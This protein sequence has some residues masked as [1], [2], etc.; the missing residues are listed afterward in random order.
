MLDKIE[1][2]DAEI[3]VIANVNALVETK[4]AD[5]RTH[6][7]EQAAHAVRWEESVRNL[8]AGG[9]DTMVECGPGTVLSG[10]MRKIDKKYRVL[11][12]GKYRNDYRNRTSIKRSLIM[13]KLEKTALVT[14]ASRGIGRAIALTLGQAGYAVAVNYAGSEAAAEAVKNEIIAAGGKAFTLQGDV[15]DPED[16]EHMFEK[17]KEG[18][19]FL[20]VLVNNAGITR[21]SLLIRMKESSWDEVIATNLKGNFLVLKA[22]AA[23]MIRRKRIC[24][25]YFFSCRSYG[26]CRAGKLCSSKSGGYRY[27][28]SGCQ[29]TGIPRY[30]CQC[31]GSGMYRD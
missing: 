11:S 23:M 17:I 13:E 27:D 30:P 1:I 6:L 18:F 10:F 31:G 25:Q 24:H 16:V 28:E 2:K 26:K 7:V 15:S 5:I 12:R 3:P 8:I 9:M 21:D 29:R 19:G 4:A 20:D 22:A 14:G